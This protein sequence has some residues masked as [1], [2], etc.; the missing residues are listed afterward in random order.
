MNSPWTPTRRRDVKG[1]ELTLR[2]AA[3]GKK[4]F[5]MCRWPKNGGWRFG[6]GAR[7]FFRNEHGDFLAMNVWIWTRENRDFSPRNMGI[8]PTW[9]SNWLGWWWK[10]K[11]SRVLVI[12]CMGFW[13]RRL[14]S[15][16]IFQ[17]FEHWTLPPLNFDGWQGK[18]S[19]CLLPGIT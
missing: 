12:V 8:Q 19:L 1:L 11:E 9:S 5:V 17:L 6:E 18:P 13:H 2:L 4:F 10:S 7:G 14:S 15:F 16:Q 3:F